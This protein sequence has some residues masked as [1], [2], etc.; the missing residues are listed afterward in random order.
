MGLPSIEELATQRY[1][2]TVWELTREIKILLETT[3]PEVWVKGEISNFKHHQPSGHMYFSLKDERAQIRCVMWRSRNLALRFL[4]TDGM[5]VYVRGRVE[6]YEP[7]GEYQINV[8]ELVPVGVGELQLAFEELKRRLKEEGLFDERHKKPLPPYPERIGI[9]TS[10]T[11]AA[12]RDLVSIIWRRFPSVE[13]ILCPVRVQGEGAAQE[14][15]A[16]IDAFNEYGQVDVLIVGRG[17]GSLEDLWAFNEEVVAR[18]IFRSRI[19]VISAVGHEIDFSIADFVA[20]YRA[21][22]PS[23]AAEKVVRDREEVLRHIRQLMSK[24]YRLLERR[25]A[26]HWDRLRGIQNSYGFRR[27]EGLVSQ[28]RQR[29]DDLTRRLETALAHRFEVHRHKLEGLRQRLETLSPEATLRRGYSITIDAAT[30]KL[31][32]AATELRNSRI[33]V[34]LWRGRLEAAVIE[35]A[36]HETWQTLEVP[37]PDTIPPGHGSDEGEGP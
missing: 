12:I 32:R 9:V 2:Y 34:Q 14:I 19:P 29:L 23:A 26:N 35:K 11:G 3:I 33:L 8:E 25:I 7:R 21:A 15:A 5:M 13:L 1:V 30:G 4:P 22:T 27:P 24:S 10:E 31:L 16:A 6:V 37:R 28:H 20:D 18:A 17:G 36:P